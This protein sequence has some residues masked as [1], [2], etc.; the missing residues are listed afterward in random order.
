MI[1]TCQASWSLGP[2][3][4]KILDTEFWSCML[5]TVR[6]IASLAV[7]HHQ[8]GYAHSS[9][10][11]VEDCN[12]RWGWWY[13]PLF[14]LCTFFAFGTYWSPKFHQNFLASP[15][16]TFSYIYIYIY[17]YCHF[18]LTEPT[19]FTTQHTNRVK[20]LVLI[21]LLVCITYLWVHNSHPSLKLIF[22]FLHT[23]II[24]LKHDSY[25]IY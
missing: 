9:I 15:K 21:D 5:A 7:T 12:S 11:G 24:I 18:I 6:K 23:R 1:G 17:I 3:D 14:Q 4:R 13:K 25:I 16:I 20:L 10:L 19:T 22:F 2:F 8:L